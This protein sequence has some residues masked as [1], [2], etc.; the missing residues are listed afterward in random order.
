MS[1][2][3]REDAYEIQGKRR[4]KMDKL[5]REDWKE[6]VK[7]ACTGSDELEFNDYYNPSGSTEGHETGTLSFPRPIH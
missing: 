3:F 4:K 7:Y 5:I 2:A 1:S 6:K